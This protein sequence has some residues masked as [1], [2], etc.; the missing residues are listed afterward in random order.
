MT[1]STLT[2]ADRKRYAGLHRAKGRRGEGAF[3]LEGTRSIAAALDA[4]ADVLDVMLAPS[5][6]P[7]LHI[8]LRGSD[9]RLI[10]ATD[11]DVADASGVQTHQGAIARVRIPNVDQ[12][13]IDRCG[14]DS[15]ARR[16]SGPR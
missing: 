7:D 4:S 1:D 2:H 8:R 15:R 12:S 3:L 6:D 14:A 5:V 16:H 11:R 9:V 10:E 13:A